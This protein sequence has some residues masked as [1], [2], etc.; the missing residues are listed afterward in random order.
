VPTRRPDPAFA[1][2]VG[3]NLQK[4]RSANKLTQ[5]AFAEK[6]GVSPRYIQGIEAG[7]RLPS[8]TIADALRRALKTTWNNLLG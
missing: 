7:T 6:V 5:E 2:R 8:L 1:N 4:L 3:R